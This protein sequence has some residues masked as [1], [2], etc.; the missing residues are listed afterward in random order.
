[1]EIVASLSS[2]R[3]PRLVVVDGAQALAHVPIDLQGSDVYLAGCHKW[4][5]AGHPLG[6]AFHPR[7]RSREFLRNVAEDMLADGDMNDP[8]LLF[9]VQLENRRLEPFS[10]TV[11]L[12]GLFSCAA[13]AVTEMDNSLE[14]PARLQIRLANA[15]ALAEAA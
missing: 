6:L 4:L 10:E 8:L 5:G 1:A 12:A 13:A 11:S 15:A 9:T 3:P 7:P 2:V 14:P